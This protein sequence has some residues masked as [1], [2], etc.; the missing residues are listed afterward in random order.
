LKS[1]DV[2]SQKFK[3]KGSA[4]GLFHRW[5]STI[6]VKIFSEMW[7]KLALEIKSK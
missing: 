7:K 2:V 6:V 1:S 4:D 3:E 5:K